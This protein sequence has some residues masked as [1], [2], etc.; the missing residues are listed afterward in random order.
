[1]EPYAL[2]NLRSNLSSMIAAGRGTFW[3]G[4]HDFAMLVEVTCAGDDTAAA[5]TLDLPP[6]DRWDIRLPDLSVQEMKDLIATIDEIEEELGPLTGACG[7]CGVK[8]PLFHPEPYL[9]QG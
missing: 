8:E 2:A 5:L 6:V 7:A 1:M 9:R 3:F 4:D